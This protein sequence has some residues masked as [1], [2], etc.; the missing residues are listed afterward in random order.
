MLEEHWQLRLFYVGE[1]KVKLFI[2][3]NCMSIL[4][5]HSLIDKHVHV[6][7]I[8][9]KNR[10]HSDLGVL[11]DCFL[12]LL[13]IGDVHHG[14]GNSGSIRHLIEVPVCS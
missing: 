4:H 12:K 13:R 11:L 6:G 5:S 14:V 7:S 8:C 10:Y 1:G 9:N 2:T 3:N